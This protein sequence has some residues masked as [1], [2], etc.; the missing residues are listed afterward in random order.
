MKRKTGILMPVASLPS[1]FGIGDFGPDAFR[2]ID[3][4]AEAGFTIWQI[5]PLNPLGY[6]NSPY[7][8]F[9][10]F[11]MDEL[12]L[13][14]DFLEEEGL[15]SHVP[16]FPGAKS[17]SIDYVGIRKLKDPYLREAFSSF[18]PDQDY[19]QF[20]SHDWLKEYAIF[21]TLKKEKLMRP[22]TEWEKELRDYPID[23]AL[24]LDKYKEEIEFQY[25]LQYELIRQ[26]EKLKAY[27][28]KKGLIIMGDI[29]FYVGLDS[30][31]CWF[32]RSNFLLDEDGHPR[33]IAGVPPDYFSNTGQRWGN[34]IYDWDYMEK[35]DFT[36]WMK[37][38][39]YNRKLFD[40][41]RLDHFR[42]FDTYWKIPAECPTAVEGEWIEAPGYQFFDK[43][44]EKYPDINIIAED[45]GDLRPS[46]LTLRDHYHFAGMNV[47]TFTFNP[48]GENE[49][50]EHCLAYTGTHDNETL[51][52]WYQSKSD[53][54]KRAWRKWFTKHE[55]EGK[56]ICEKFLRFALQSKAEMVI[57]PVADWLQLGPEACLNHP[58]T[59]GSPNWEWRMP[60]FKAF[61][62]KIPWIREMIEEAHRLPS[63]RKAVV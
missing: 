10:S 46:V 45:L 61:E 43:L 47:L 26:W 55:Y 62:K 1:R 63:R 44:F 2:F 21:M 29:P 30:A 23:R 20:I 31:D 40:V 14:L 42:A 57:I 8:P 58:G 18:R 7:Q 33:F 36:F 28:N 50:I 9:S 17:K 12:Y 27:A 34:P 3:H 53:K 22:W 32:G 60:D 4:I 51:R 56:N 38:L 37:R 13:S 24:S 11:A 5:L 16:D 52:G 19:K 6:G 39:G 48:H 15:V 54:E 25:F 49:V 35:H 41:I 59:V